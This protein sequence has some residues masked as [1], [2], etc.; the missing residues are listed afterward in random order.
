VLTYELPYTLNET[1][2]FASKSLFINLA[3]SVD[4]WEVRILWETESVSFWLKIKK[5]SYNTVKEIF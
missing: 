3:D 5:D 1:N 4:D 2:S